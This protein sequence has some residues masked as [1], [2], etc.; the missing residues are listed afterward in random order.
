MNELKGALIVIA[1]ILIG[2]SIERWAVLR[3]RRRRARGEMRRVIRLGDKSVENYWR[4]KQEPPDDGPE[5][6]Y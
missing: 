2:V 6:D 4:K 3:A 5:G 1:L